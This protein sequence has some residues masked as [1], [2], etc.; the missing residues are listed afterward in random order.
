MRRFML[1]AAVLIAALAWAGCS[2]A[3]SEQHRSGARIL[4][5]ALRAHEPGYHATL[6]EVSRTVRDTRTWAASFTRA[7]SAGDVEKAIAQIDSARSRIRNLRRDLGGLHVDP[8]LRLELLDP[9][10]GQ[11]QAQDI[12]LLEISDHINRAYRRYRDSD[13]TGDMAALN[14][15]L[16][17]HREPANLLAPALRRIR[18]QYGIARQRLWR[19]RPL[20]A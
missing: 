11:L 19:G 9:I 20:T 14:A 5:R 17:R 15:L 4:F 2:L 6:H 7:T 13:A 3:G 18:E 1:L 8:D 10:L 12:E 16:D